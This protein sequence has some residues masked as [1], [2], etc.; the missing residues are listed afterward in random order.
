MRKKI[1][2]ILLVIAIILLSFIIML[3]LYWIIRIVFFGATFGGKYPDSI[4]WGEVYLHGLSGIKQY[5]S[6]YGSIL[7]LTELPIAILSIIYQ[8]IYFKFLRK[9]YYINF[10]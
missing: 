6:T 3:N 7:L 8:F 9:W 1:V 2:F 5:Y 10:K 4:W